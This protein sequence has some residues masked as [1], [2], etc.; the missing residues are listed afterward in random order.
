MTEILCAV[1]IALLI[2]VILILIFKK[3]KSG[4]EQAQQSFNEQGLKIDNLSANMQNLSQLSTTQLQNMNTQLNDVYKS[5]GEMKSM[6]SDIENLR[7]VLGNVKSRGYFA[8]VQ[9]DHL[10]EQVIPG[11]YEKNVKPNPRSGNIVEFAIKIP[12]GKDKGVTWLPV[13]SK[14]P[15]DRYEQLVKASD[16]NDALAIEEARKALISQIDRQATDIKNKYIVVPYTTNFAVMYL[17]TEG[18]YM[19][20]VTDPDGLQYKLQERGIMIAGPSTILALL[21]SLSMGFNM[22]K[23]NENADEIRRSLGDIKRQFDDFNLSFEEISKGLEKASSS[24][25]NAKRRSELITKKLNKL[26]FDED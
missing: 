18:M 24:L 9:L 26:D 16:T 4:N 14:F 6:S 5:L 2:V 20:A 13:D 19:E 7:K 12:N 11:M 1:I 15:M 8:E 21:N 22:I 10:L 3:S 23:I 17:P 25:D